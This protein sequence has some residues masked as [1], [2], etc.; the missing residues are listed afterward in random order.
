MGLLYNMYNA[1]SC[2][3]VDYLMFEPPNVNVT[4]IKVVTSPANKLE[5]I[6]Q[7]IEYSCEI[8]YLGCGYDAK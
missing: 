3:E 1:V 2:P 4:E 7:K 8:F 6:K 5:G